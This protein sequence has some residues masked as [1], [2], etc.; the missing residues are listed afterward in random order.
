MP[1][2]RVYP[3]RNPQTGEL[4]FGGSGLV[5]RPGRTQNDLLA[6]GLIE[7]EDLDQMPIPEGRFFPD[8]PSSLT[9]N[10]DLVFELATYIP[11]NDII[12]KELGWRLGIEH[13]GVDGSIWWDHP[14]DND[15][16]INPGNIEFLFYRNYHLANIQGDLQH[17]LTVELPLV[18]SGYRS[19]Y[20]PV[21][22]PEY[23]L[24]LNE[25]IEWCNY[26]VERIL[27]PWV[28]SYYEECQRRPCPREVTR[29]SESQTLK[30][31]E[32]KVRAQRAQ[33]FTYIDDEGT[34]IGDW[35]FSPWYLSIGF[36]R[37]STFFFSREQFLSSLF[38]PY[39]AVDINIGASNQIVI[40]DGFRDPA[41][42]TDYGDIMRDNNVGH[43]VFQQLSFP[44][45]LGMAVEVGV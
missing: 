31:T 26:D 7:Q 33:R 45:K 4:R 11:D 43:Y 37:D 18:N 8:L 29:E 3:Y 30:I 19:N 38:L 22:N 28:F 16:D 9:V 13:C 40:D 21:Q 36:L 1:N 15:P 34:D 20:P 14:P 44:L 25:T 23:R 42:P 12:S 24:D 35:L 17:N 5:L 10:L 39:G 2:V 32:I 41:A 6:W 27:E